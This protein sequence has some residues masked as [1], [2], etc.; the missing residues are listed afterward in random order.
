MLALRAF[1]SLFAAVFVGSAAAA[2]IYARDPV[3]TCYPDI[4]HDEGVLINEYA[5]YQ[6]AYPSGS[7]VWISAVG[8]PVASTVLPV[9]SPFRITIVNRPA[10]C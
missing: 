1:T 9:D 8:F 2:T 7:C 6:C 3:C 5:S 4:Y 10:N